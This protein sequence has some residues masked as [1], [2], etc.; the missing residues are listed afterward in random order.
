MLFRTRLRQQLSVPGLDALVSR[1]KAGVKTPR[2]L[3]KIPLY[4]DDT[5]AIGVKV[6]SG[7]VEKTKPASVNITREHNQKVDT[8][9][10]HYC[11]KTDVQ[12]TGKEL[13]R[14]AKFGKQTAVVFEQKEVAEMKTFGKPGLYLMGF[15]PKARLKLQY[16]VKNSKF[17]RPDE[18][19]IEGS[20]ALF[21]AL[22]ARL[23]A[24]EQVAICRLVA[25]YNSPPDFVG[26]IPQIEKVVDGVTTPGGFHMVYIPYADDMRKLPYDSEAPKASGEQIGAMK[27]IIRKLASEKFPALDKYENYSLAKFHKYIEAMVFNRDEAVVTDTMEMD[28]A[29]MEQ[30]AGPEIAAFTELVY[31]PEYDPSAKPKPASKRK[32]KDDSGGGAAKKPKKEPLDVSGLDVKGMVAAGTL[33][34]LKVTEIRAIL[35]SIGQPTTGK[36]ADLIERVESTFPA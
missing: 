15:K 7:A 14:S 30:K 1:V 17:L 2:T 32:A 9:T 11:P 6:Y 23:A 12:L 27:D 35:S 3:M 13:K 4:M 36:K 29:G 20:S 18:T 33:K 10:T 25:R 28:T 16:N 21:N 19:V 34:K 31:P 22:L 5:S 8:V 24:R 26:L